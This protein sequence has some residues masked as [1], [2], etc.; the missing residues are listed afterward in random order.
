[1]PNTLLILALAAQAS[2]FMAWLTA[3]GALGSLTT[4]APSPAYH[5]MAHTLRRRRLVLGR[6]CGI[7]GRR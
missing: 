1:M 5:A 4:L 6:P 7:S 2:L 3:T